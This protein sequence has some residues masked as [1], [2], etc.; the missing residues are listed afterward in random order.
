MKRREPLPRFQEWRFP[1]GGGGKDFGKRIEERG[2]RRSPVRFSL[3]R[4]R[5]A[6][7]PQGAARRVRRSQRVAWEVPRWGE[8]PSH[9]LGIA[10][11]LAS[12]PSE[13]KNGAP[14]GRQ[15]PDRR[16]RSR[17]SYQPV[18]SPSH[19]PS[20]ESVAS[21][22]KDPIRCEFGPQDK[23][24]EALRSGGKMLHWH[25]LG[26]LIRVLPVLSNVGTRGTGFLH[27]KPASRFRDSLGTTAC[28]R[29][30]SSRRG[31]F[32]SHEEMFPST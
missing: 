29:D 20:G 3:A 19:P 11:S 12:G 25:Q 24:T 21:E 9:S 28:R 18:L 10:P 32:P 27:V 23:E 16:A 30:S 5:A 8:T 2:N 6:S 17:A 14:P 7:A 31:L 4:G 13:E 1:R 22:H 26:V 15:R